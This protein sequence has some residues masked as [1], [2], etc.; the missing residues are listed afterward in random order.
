[1]KFVG[2]KDYIVRVKG[3]NNGEICNRILSGFG[4]FV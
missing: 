3:W 4:I 2:N 1:M